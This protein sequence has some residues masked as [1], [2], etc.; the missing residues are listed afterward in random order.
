MGAL[1]WQ[2][3]T[4]VLCQCLNSSTTAVGRPKPV[5]EPWGDAPTPF[6]DTAV[7]CAGLPVCWRHCWRQVLLLGQQCLSRSCPVPAAPDA[8]GWVQLQLV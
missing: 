8:V 2:S 7:A 3:V 1:T 6:T 4:E 5:P